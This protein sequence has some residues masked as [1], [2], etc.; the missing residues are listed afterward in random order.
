MSDDAA[1]ARALTCSAPEISQHLTAYCFGH[2]T[3]PEQRAVEAHLLECE[4]CWQEAQRLSAAVQVLRSDRSVMQ[5]LS[6]ADIAATFGLSAK[7]PL[8][9]AGHGW[10]V[11]LSSAIYAMLYAVALLA[12]VAY[13]FDRY[14]STALKIAPLVFGWVFGA[15]LV[16]LWADWKWT[17]QGRQAGLA[18]S[19]S[20]SLLAALALFAGVCLFLP[21]SPITEANFQTYTAQAAYLKTMSYFLILAVF[22]WL[23]PFHLVIAMQRE[24]QAG[25][26]QLVL[27]LLTGD[28]PSVTPRGAIFLRFWGLS[29]LLVAMVA[30]GLYLHFHLFDNLKPGAYLNFFAQ[31]IQTR[32]I[33][34]FALGIECLAWYY[35][36]LNELKRE[37]WAIEKGIFAG[38]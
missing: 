18:L 19:V 32:L 37:C 16:G 10:H 34:Y 28:K 38:R 13:Q 5:S 14:G 26:H 17:R 21:A 1:L 31:L 2:A 30:I 33:L 22:F 24:L 8:L 6:P 7:L 35:R 9:F 36:A 3:E 12:E 20:I 27:G 4:C 11:F 23:A 15:A 29:L 25:R